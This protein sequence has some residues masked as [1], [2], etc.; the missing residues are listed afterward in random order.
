VTAAHEEP[1]GQ[2]GR[3]SVA[4]RARL[5]LVGSAMLA[6]AVAFGVFTI[7]W[8]QYTIQLRTLDLS[9]QVAALAKGQAAAGAQAPS[10]EEARLRLLRI[11]AGLIGAALFETD[12]D[13]RIERSTMASPP[14]SIPL[15]RL[16]RVDANGTR[17]G[18]LRSGT[19]VQVLGVAAPIDR[20][21]E[22]VA[23]QGLAEI[24]AERFDLLAIAAVGMLVAAIVAYIAGGVLARRLTAP[25][26]R[27]RAAA[28]QVAEGEYGTQ[29]PVEGDAETASLAHSFNEMSRRVAD[30]YAAL[31]AFVGDVSHEIRT[32]LTSIRGFAEAMLDGTVTDP[33][34]QRRALTVIRDE[35][36]RIGEVSRTLLGLAELDSGAVEV[37]RVPVDLGVM[38]D[39]LL[40]RFSAI[41]EAEGLTLGIAVPR[42]PRPLADPERLLQAISTLVANAIAYTPADGQVR[43]SAEE[44]D[45]RWILA[46]DDS[47]PGIPADKREA[48]FGRFTRLDESR[49]TNGGG[50][51]LGLAICAR[52][53]ELMSGTVG[54]NDSD[55][56]GARFEIE[57]P[58]A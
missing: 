21:H 8:L 33:D 18:V 1:F 35:S 39:A 31:K 30:T 2:S 44:R 28:E 10:A 43:V 34:Q 58:L 24:R 36:V 37:A 13:G 38:S 54:V 17:S 25:L 55:L 15:A 16:S 53:V 52:L 12:A 51:G 45:G 47:G 40:G 22:L 20:A 6:L 4:T 32:P 42:T 50:A 56:G 11:E 23:V 19:G 7:V 26:V 49:S 48:V 27:L 46:V 41:A 9:R 14:S 29:V 3:R 5:Y 57:L